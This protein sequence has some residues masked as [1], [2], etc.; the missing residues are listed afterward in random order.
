[1]KVVRDNRK[2]RNEFQLFEKFDAGIK[3]AGTEVKSV[4]EGRVSLDESYCR[5]KGNEL[6]LISCDISHY[7]PAG[8]INHNPKRD[9]KL[10]LHKHELNRL[11]GKLRAKSCTVIPVK[12]YIT[13]NNLVKLEIAL[14]TRFTKY[15]KREKI[16]EKDIQKRIRS[17]GKKWIK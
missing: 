11:S 3:L 5:F 2:A 17:V 7:A 1:M 16:K 8:G 13:D 15:D 9:R 10:L 4:R 6:Y 12:M 14:A